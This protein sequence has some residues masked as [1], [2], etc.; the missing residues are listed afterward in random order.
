MLQTSG[1]LRTK[2]NTCLF[3]PLLAA[4]APLCAGIGLGVTPLCPYPQRTYD[5]RGEKCVLSIRE[6]DLTQALC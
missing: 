3:F 1:L 5:F 6:E 4:E 2:K